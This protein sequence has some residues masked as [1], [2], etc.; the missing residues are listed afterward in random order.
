MIHISV[1]IFVY[2]DLLQS[3]PQD[4]AISFDQ[5]SAGPD[6]AVEMA[7]SHLALLQV[8]S[9]QLVTSSLMPEVSPYLQQPCLD[10]S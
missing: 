5:V 4:E 8:D 7:S 1:H 10:V 3:G 9:K 2:N 6:M